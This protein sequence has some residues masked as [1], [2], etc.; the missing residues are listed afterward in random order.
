MTY[1]IQ[2][3][4]VLFVYASCDLRNCQDIFALA[5]IVGI[6]DILDLTGT[7]A[8]GACADV[9]DLIP[10]L[11]TEGQYCLATSLELRSG[12]FVLGAAAL[13]Q[14]LALGVMYALVRVDKHEEPYYPLPRPSLYERTAS[15]MFGSDKITAAR[16]AIDVSHSGG[17]VWAHDAANERSSFARTDHLRGHSSYGSMSNNSFD[18]AASVSS[19]RRAARHSVNE[20]VR[21]DDRG[22]CAVQ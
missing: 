2:A 14:W 9:A 4:R 1:S 16:D 11:I 12:A 22:G 8:D 19:R 6:F 21:G 7:L 10:G 3:R 20:I 18:S 17:A 13:V 15:L 5:L